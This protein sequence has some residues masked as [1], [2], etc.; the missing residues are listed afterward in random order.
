MATTTPTI[1]TVE[2]APHVLKTPVWVLVVRV[3][4][5]I[6]SIV[7]LGLAAWII[8]GAYIDSAG[9]SLAVV[10]RPLPR[11]RKGAAS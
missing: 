5:I 9:L 3:F 10:S 4:Q 11:A 2:G 8:N 6:I 1:P 7:I